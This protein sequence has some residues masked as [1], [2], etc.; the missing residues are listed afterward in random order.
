MTSRVDYDR[1]AMTYDARYSGRSY[2]GVMSALRDLARASGP[3]RALEAGCGTGFWLAALRD[4]VPHRYGI[5]PSSNML[6]RAAHR[7]SGS[8]LVRAAAEV[9]PF[10][11]GTFDLIFCINAVHHFASFP[12]F[13]AEA[14]RMLCPG[15]TLAVF[16]MDPHRGRDSWCVYDYFPDTKKTDL[17]RFPS[18]G[19]IVDTMLQAGFD[20]VDC[21]IASRLVETR[22]GRAVFD[23]PELQRRGCSQMALLSD[24]QYAA[25]ISRIEAAIRDAPAGTPAVFGADIAM[26][27]C[28]GTV[29][30]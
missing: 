19:T 1:I 2:D 5:D 25:G 14:R 18:T 22:V 3:N 28:R 6:A 21:S 26:M 4:I 12:R 8:I 27:L 16:G 17:A 23:D 7:A 24:E 30:S 13:V 29:S 9:V 10:R 20:Q 15:G 11:S